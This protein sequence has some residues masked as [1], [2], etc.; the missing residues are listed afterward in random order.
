[1]SYFNQS[2]GVCLP[3]FVVSNV[4]LR[5]VIVPCQSGYAEMDGEHSVAKKQKSN[6]D[7]PGEINPRK[8]VR[9]PKQKSIYEP[10]PNS[11][12]DQA[13]RSSIYKKKG[14]SFKCEDCQCSFTKTNYDIHKSKERSK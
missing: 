7:G 6:D 9:T 2:Y 4:C 12:R 8:S 14:T 10:E 13:V 3:G 11:I 1:M 5:S